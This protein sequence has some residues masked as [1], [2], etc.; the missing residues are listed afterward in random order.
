[1]SNI[2]YINLLMEWFHNFFSWNLYDSSNGKENKEAGT[3]PFDVRIPDNHEWKIIESDVNNQA[4]VIFHSKRENNMISNRS[5]DCLKLLDVGNMPLLSGFHG[6]IEKLGSCQN[7]TTKFD[8]IW[9]AWTL[10]P[11][12]KLPYVTS[13]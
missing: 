11:M 5:K 1:M 7:D 6:P 8:I 12:S 9:T 3:I 10:T 2:T 13:H 4:S